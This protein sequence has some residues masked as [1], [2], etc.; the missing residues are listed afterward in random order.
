MTA[1]RMTAKHAGTCRQCKGGIE[2]GDAIYWAKGSGAIHVDCETA[3][4][5][6]TVCTN[7]NG[8]GVLWHNRPCL[9]CDGTGNRKVQ[10]FA[11]L[12]PEQRHPVPQ[13]DNSGVEDRACSDL[14]YEDRCAEQCGL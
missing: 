12:P 11:K 13:H 7:C 6:D 3:R 14:A 10:E 1:R 9:A 5:R 8:A 4:L 2:P